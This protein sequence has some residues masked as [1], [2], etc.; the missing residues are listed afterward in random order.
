MRLIEL[1][2]VAVTLIALLAIERGVSSSTIA[3]EGDRHAN[4]M[5]VWWELFARP[6][7]IPAPRDNPITQ[8]KA[9]LGKKLFS[10]KRLSG[11]QERSCASCHQS[12][13]GFGDGLKTA[14]GLDGKPLP[15]NTP[16]LWNLAWSEKFFWDGR[17]RSL[18]AQV[19][20]PLTHRQEMAGEWVQV[21]SRL[22]K[23]PDT[24]DEFARVFGPD[25]EVNRVSIER[26]LATYQRTLVSPETSFDRF[27]A[28]DQHALTPTELAG[29]DLFVGSAGCVSCHVGW[30]FTDNRFHDIGLPG[31]DPGRGVIADGVTGLKAF[32]TPGLRELSHTAPYMHDGSLLTLEDVLDHYVEG[33]I[34][35]PGVSA[36]LT[37]PLLLS[38]TER[39]QLIAFLKTLS[40]EG[41]DPRSPP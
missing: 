14:A 1:C 34:D 9:E 2:I 32:K 25:A 41:V 16:S 24:V 33:I 8:S 20:I 17:M 38:A 27:I 37:R 26:A 12:R 15:R 31:D 40:S 35:R 19:G 29:F 4:L 11:H 10:D 18:E 21:V 28:G 7:S 3:D 22:A 6:R 23:D 39:V 36:N 5:E 30:R 13:L